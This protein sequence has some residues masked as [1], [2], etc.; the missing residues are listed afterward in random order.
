[1]CAGADHRFKI[2]ARGEDD[3][4]RV[5]LQANLPG[6]LRAV[7]RRMG[8]TQIHQYNIRLFHKRGLHRAFSVCAARAKLEIR[9]AAERLFD[10][11]AIIEVILDQH[12][13]DGA[14]G[15]RLPCAASG[16]IRV[17]VQPFPGALLTRILPSCTFITFW[18]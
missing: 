3:D 6:S 17:K 8:E 9:L 16:K 18:Q 10:Q 14:H 11:I 15:L 7:Y 1:M 12:D 2:L 13:A 4:A 5:G